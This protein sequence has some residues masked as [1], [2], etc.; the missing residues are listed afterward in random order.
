MPKSLYMLLARQRQQSRSRMQQCRH[1]LSRRLRQLLMMFYRVSGLVTM[2]AFATGPSVAEA[3]EN[4]EPLSSSSRKGRS[5]DDEAQLDEVWTL[6]ADPCPDE[7]G[8]LAVCGMDGSAQWGGDTALPQADDQ[9]DWTLARP[10]IAGVAVLSAIAAAGGGRS[11]DGRDEPA[12]S[13]PARDGGHAAA[14]AAPETGRPL[15]QLPAA[16]PAMTTAPSPVAETAI[17]AAA[18]PAVV[19]AVA[20]VP[21]RSV[22]DDG[23]PLSPRT[24][25][26]RQAPAHPVSLPA[27]A[28]VQPATDG[29]GE[30][31]GLDLLG[32]RLLLGRSEQMSNETV[33]RNGT[34]ALQDNTTFINRGQVENLQLAADG[35]RLHNAAGARM[36]LGDGGYSHF[37]GGARIDN[38]GTLILSRTLAG[39]GVL[40]NQA[41]ARIQ[42]GGAGEILS[43]KSGSFINHGEIQATGAMADGNHRAIFV[44][45]WATGS[46]VSVNTGAMQA[47]GGYGVMATSHRMLGNGRDVFVNRGRIDFTAENGATRAL[48]VKAHH[49]GHDLLNDRDGVITV[50]G[51]NATAMRS[52][53]DSQ[54][55]NRGI[56]NL[57]DENGSD[58][59]MVA[60]A[61]G[62]GASGAIVNDAGGVIDIRARQSYAFR[63][64]GRSGTLINRGEVRLNC[65]DDSCGVFADNYSRMRNVRGRAA[66]ADFAFQPR[67]GEDVSAMLAVLSSP[68]GGIGRDT[69][70]ASK[71]A[72]ADERPVVFATGE[73]QGQTLLV[74]YQRQLHHENTL[75][76]GRLLVA[77]KA[78]FTNRGV[79]DRVAL[80]V[81][82][83]ADNLA[84]GRM[85]LAR[86]APV[87]G[88]F[89]NQ[90]GA[91]IRLHGEGTLHVRQNGAFLNHGTITAAAAQPDAAGR[92]ILDD[93]GASGAAERINTGSLTASGGYGVLKTSG[94]QSAGRNVFINRGHID[95]T[96]Q[97]GASQALHV[98]AQ[99][100]GHDI[101]NDQGG[102]ISV[103]G[104]HAVAMR[105]DSDSL[106]V[107]RGTL[108]LGERGTGETGM[109]AMALGPAATGTLV[110]DVNGVIDIRARQ[111]YAFSVE[112]A[113][114]TLINRGTVR[115]DCDDGSC[116]LYRDVATRNR[117]ASGTAAGNGQQAQAESPSSRAAQPLGGYVIGTLP[118]GSAGTLSGTHLDARGVTVDTGFTSGTAARTVTF[119]RVLQGRQVDGIDQIGSKTVAWRAQAHRGSDGSVS[120][121]M[122][123]N[124]YRDLMTDAA[125]RPIA[126]ALERG[127]DGGSLYRSLELRSA[128]DVTDAVRQLSGGRIDQAL[129][130]LRVLEQRFGRMTDTA[131]PDAAGLRFSLIGNGTPGSQLGASS[132]DMAVVGQRF[133]L[134]AR[135]QIDAHYGIASLRPQTGK[136]DEGLKGISQVFGLRH[137]GA[138]AGGVRLE[139]GF[140]YALH[141][142]NSKRTLRYGEV[143]EQASADHR[144]DQFSGQINLAW[145]L[146]PVTGLSMEPLVGI[147]LRHQRDAGLSEQGAGDYGLQLSSQRQTVLDGVLGLRVGYDG[148]HPDTGRGWRVDAALNARPAL[149]R[150][151]G[152]RMAQL[153]GAPGVRFALPTAGQGSRF[154]HD[155]RLSISRQ[156]KEGR[157]SL[158]AYLSRDEGSRDKGIMVDYRHAF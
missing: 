18:A 149:F 146:K 116:G 80:E 110:N 26:L 120:V 22:M 93:G 60:M 48:H 31:T 33:L 135:S 64:E 100:A 42:L 157:F 115:L 98:K 21:A 109:V 92:A 58:R 17:T 61:L 95:F 5:R 153:N 132:H 105:S 129:R 51:D 29:A 20:T 6:P 117:D 77:D 158:G 134:G 27:S 123:K 112:G 68:P 125:L 24:V 102:M 71:P 150:Q 152:E 53:S 126:D 66:D 1:G 127:Y 15:R 89:S 69:V 45:G 56:I 4:A 121:T 67:L 107:N 154:A 57:G 99:H 28:A 97:N 79:L 118:D 49:R 148:Q 114:G 16:E 52:D 147:R 10:A 59:G 108:R 3:R 12:S 90:A 130:P 25:S 91:D 88:L 140:Q 76:N 23:A 111:S 85:V 13:L 144:R 30:R 122:S 50:R 151:Q 63:V 54:L 119:D 36:T 41:G 133:E 55:V 44:D 106:L 11:G 46:G 83:T 101:L 40:V 78:A 39:S 138:L 73:L 8:N 142:L 84:G 141:R 65:G 81:A 74:D 137:A 32:Q 14:G 43:G 70:A 139:S 9:P 124:D 96:A 19:T 37:R 155:G 35:G 82:G 104:S 87:R 156:G 131:R 47:S 128:G 103:R 145:S 34:L 136:G 113:A 75:R 72:P 86:P 7:P 94:A 38:S 2:M 62:S 143:S